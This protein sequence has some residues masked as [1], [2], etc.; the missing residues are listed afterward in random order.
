M[1]TLYYNYPVKHLNVCDNWNELTQSQFIRIAKL[2]HSGIADTDILLDKALQILCDKSLYKF[3]LTPFEVRLDAYEHVKWIFEEQ[4]GITKQYITEY[5]G[6]H[7]PESE[8]NNLKLAEFHHAEMAFYIFHKEQTI[9]AL[10]EFVSVLYREPKKNYD[11][12]RNPDG[13]SRVPFNYQDIQW[14]KRK[15]K[16]WPVEVKQ[17]IAMWY[18]GCKELLRKIYPTVFASGNT[19][20]GYFEGM[21]SIIRNIAGDK[22]GSFNDVEQMFVHLAFKELCCLIEEQQELEKQLN[23]QRA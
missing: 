17:A 16:K 18:A 21:F 11:R 1:K 5:D 23:T 20:E 12:D 7:G 14:N 10:D 8:F 4:Q 6:L 2:L 19:D 13:D 15:I 9:D 3:L 22:Y